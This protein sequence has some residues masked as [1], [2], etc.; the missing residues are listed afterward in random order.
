MKHSILCIDDES[1]NLEALKRLFRK[2]YHVITA[3]SGPKALEEL[4]KQKI[5]LIISDQ[6]MPEMTGVEFFIKAKKI[7]PDAIRILLTGYTNLESVID[8]INQGQIYRYITKP[9][10][11]R[12]FFK[13]R[14]TSHRSFLK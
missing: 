13:Y 11:P 12:E 6:K 9:W 7:Q 4:G 2:N 1:Y 8:A 10:E 3:L 14:F 5:A